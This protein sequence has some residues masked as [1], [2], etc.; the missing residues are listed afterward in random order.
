MNQQF[1][2]PSSTTVE[3]PYYS[4]YQESR[5]SSG[6]QYYSAFDATKKWQE[7][8]R[9]ELETKA[10]AHKNVQRSP[11][12]RRGSYS[13]TAI[14]RKVMHA[15]YASA[16]PRNENEI[17]ICSFPQAKL[18]REQTSY[19]GN[20]FFRAARKVRLVQQGLPMTPIKDRGSRVREARL[21]EQGRPQEDLQQAR[22]ASSGSVSLF[23]DDPDRS[24]YTDIHGSSQSHYQR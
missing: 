15:L 9:K 1:D 8:S 5:P 13:D 6:E 21:I 19:P 22:Q 18:V 16:S 11:A 7:I 4:T 23:V 20:S 17:Y 2:Q 24:I 10:K 3:M 14:D 12:I